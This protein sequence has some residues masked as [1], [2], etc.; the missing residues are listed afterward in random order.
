MSP[1][2]ENLVLFSQLGAEIGNICG[3]ARQQTAKR[4]KFR[5][6]DRAQDIFVAVHNVI[7]ATL[8]NQQVGIIPQGCYGLATGK[9]FWHVAEA[10]MA[11][12]LRQ[13]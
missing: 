11:Q 10:L 2:P 8:R 3:E 6:G 13:N 7:T 5:R 12:V 1:E 4:C 9:A